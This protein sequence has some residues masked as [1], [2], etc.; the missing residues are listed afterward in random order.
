MVA[1]AQMKFASK[2]KTKLVYS[3]YDTGQLAQSEAAS[4]VQRESVS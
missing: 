4:T 2:N 3:P 1:T